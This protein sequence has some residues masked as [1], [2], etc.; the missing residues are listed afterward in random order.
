MVDEARNVRG[1]RD[2]DDDEI[3]ERLERNEDQEIRLD[4]EVNMGNK[5]D[6]ATGLNCIIDDPRTGEAPWSIWA[7]REKMFIIV[8]ASVAAFFSPI[9]AQIYLPALVPV[10]VDLKVSYGLINLSVTTYLVWF[11]LV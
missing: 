8:T 2:V 10:A 3:R 1:E 4:A 7:P 5:L 6:T 11:S 9:P